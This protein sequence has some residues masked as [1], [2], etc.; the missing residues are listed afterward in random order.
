MAQSGSLMALADWAE[1][2]RSFAKRNLALQKIFNFPSSWQC[3][4]HFF[5]EGMTQDF[6]FYF[7]E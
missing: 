7:H 5:L 6:F 1:S 3:Q 2:G 4:L